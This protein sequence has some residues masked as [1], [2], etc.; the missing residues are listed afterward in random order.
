[1]TDP[2]GAPSKRPLITTYI[3][4]D[5]TAGRSVTSGTTEPHTLTGESNRHFVVV[6]CH[7]DGTEAGAWGVAAGSVRVG[8]SFAA[9]K[10]NGKGERRAHPQASSRAH[11]VTILHLESV[12]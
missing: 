11:C 1:M 2:C 3:V 4:E 5:S 7:L 9:A 8:S 6:A 10:R 12:P